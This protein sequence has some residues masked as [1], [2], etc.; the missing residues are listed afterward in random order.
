MAGKKVV[1]ELLLNSGATAD[2]KDNKGE[3]PLDYA[4]RIPGN[5]TKPVLV[6]WL[7]KHPPAKAVKKN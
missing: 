7:L 3:T 4:D 1:V 6:F 2:A 5:E